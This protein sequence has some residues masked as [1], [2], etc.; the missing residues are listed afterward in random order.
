VP[1]NPSDAELKRA[2]SDPT[3]PPATLA[4]LAYDHPELR[5]AIVHNPATYDGLL[6]WLG[7][8][9][10]SDVQAALKQRVGA[11]PAA[12]PEQV[13]DAA[14][15]TRAPPVAQVPSVQKELPIEKATPV[16]KTLA[17][18]AA[19]DV[20]TCRNCSSP[21]RA[22]VNYCGNCGTLIPGQIAYRTVGSLTPTANR[23]VFYSSLVAMAVILLVV[24]GS[25]VATTISQIQPSTVVSAQGGTSDSPDSGASGDPSPSDATPAASP[26]L[27]PAAPE[28]YDFRSSSGNITC[29]ITPTSAIC[30]QRLIAYAM[31]AEACQSGVSGV[32]IGVNQSGTEWPCLSAAIPATTIVA[33]DQSVVQWGYTCVID[34]TTGV[35]CENPNGGG[36]RMEYH[37]GVSTF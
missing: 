37:A 35:N 33:Y 36:F 34:Y 23:A 1:E 31:P 16:E 9:A 25:T 19:R 24:T 13:A 32:T 21:L 10:D 20:E 28:V 30:N 3:T 6:E 5:V 7:E 15:I 14:T 27:P 11:P 22:T 4:D 8:L 29:E 17:A 18:K 2:A 12:D 26:T